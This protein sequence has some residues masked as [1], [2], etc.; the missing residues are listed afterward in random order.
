MHRCSTEK[1]AAPICFS[2]F[3]NIKSSFKDIECPFKVIECPF[4]D[5]E[6]T[7]KSFERRFQEYKDDIY[8]NKKLF[9]LAL[10]TILLI[11]RVDHSYN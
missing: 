4:K 2:I 11:E 7:F 9:L 1:V 8:S 10:K 5:T 6:R 3:S